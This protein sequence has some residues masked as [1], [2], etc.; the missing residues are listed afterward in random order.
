MSNT[1]YFDLLNALKRITAA[2]THG[3][4]APVWEDIKAQA[5]A[6]IARAE[7]TAQGTLT[8]TQVIRYLNGHSGD[9]PFCGS[10]NLDGDSLEMNINQVTQ[11]VVCINCSASW[12]DTY[13]LISIEVN[14]EPDHRPAALPDSLKGDEGWVEGFNNAQRGRL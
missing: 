7:P 3:N 5:R 8:D 9:C 11:D 4:G 2:V 6:A 13:Q 1:V 14:E 12:T 10:S